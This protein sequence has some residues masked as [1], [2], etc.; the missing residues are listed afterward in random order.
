MDFIK[1]K[2]GSKGG[3]EAKRK[4]SK[5]YCILVNMSK[6]TRERERERERER[7]G[8]IGMHANCLENLA[9]HQHCIGLLALV[10]HF[11]LNPSH[12]PVSKLITAN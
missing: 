12:L 10:L 9:R 11:Y 3:L 4:R 2:E 5:G 6:L 1:R 7:L 8:T